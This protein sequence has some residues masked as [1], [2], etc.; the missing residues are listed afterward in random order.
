MAGA[1][2]YRQ[3]EVVLQYLNRAYS[4]MIYPSTEYILV[5]VIIFALVGALKSEGPMQYG[6]GFIA[7]ACYLALAA[8]F[9]SAAEFHARSQKLLQNWRGIL[10]RH[11]PAEPR[12]LKTFPELKLKI[13]SFGFVD[14]TLILTLSGVILDNSISFLIITS[15]H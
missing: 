7:L 13:G 6:L 12:I 4:P 9:R 11:D 8:T 14:T 5:G 1:R 2:K 10:N 3:L 15:T